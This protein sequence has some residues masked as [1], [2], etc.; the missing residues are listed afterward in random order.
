MR[1]P[2]AAALVFICSATPL[3]AQGSVEAGM[4]RAEVIARLGPPAAERSSG[5][6][7]YLF[8]QSA[9]APSCAANDLVVLRGG[10][11]AD[12][13]FAAPSRGSSTRRAGAAGIEGST[14]AEVADR[15]E[16][17]SGGIV[18][19]VA[20]ARLD[21]A[22]APASRPY[23]EPGSLDAA[24]QEEDLA[25]PGALYPPFGDPLLHEATPLRVRTYVLPG[26]FEYAE[27]R[28][29]RNLSPGPGS[30]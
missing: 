4:S 7:T 16:L 25:E 9:C 14:L 3:L 29:Y 15:A 11:V 5:E 12:A 28:Q 8:Y 18:L 26:T 1:H 23:V 27:P 2:L 21:P 19:G 30:R 13:I 6:D 22:P 20:P 24:P 17:R 10:L